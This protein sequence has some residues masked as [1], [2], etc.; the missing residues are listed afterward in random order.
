[1]I[2]HHISIY[3]RCS[4]HMKRCCLSGSGISYK[5]RLL[6]VVLCVF[7]LPHLHELIFKRSVTF[8]Y[9][10]IQMPKL[11]KVIWNWSWVNIF[12]DRHEAFYEDCNNHVFQL[13]LSTTIS[14]DEKNVCFF[15]G[16]RMNPNPQTIWF[17]SSAHIFNLLPSLSFSPNK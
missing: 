6:M 10:F 3:Q 16:H 14:P 17:R 1:M 11:P 2:F 7:I 13:W 12:T 8:G 15:R 5:S 9:N 4:K